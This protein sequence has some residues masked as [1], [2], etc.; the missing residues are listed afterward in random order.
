MKL[1]LKLLYIFK[2]LVHSFLLAFIKD[3]KLI[4]GNVFIPEKTL[5]NSNEEGF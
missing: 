2:V 3:V 4:K 5:H 1:N